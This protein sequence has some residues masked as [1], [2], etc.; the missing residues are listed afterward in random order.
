LHLQV[1]ASVL[2][3]GEK[4]GALNDLKL[5]HDQKPDHETPR[6]PVAICRTGRTRRP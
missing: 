5:C 3:N 2:R 1:L 4:V 6:L